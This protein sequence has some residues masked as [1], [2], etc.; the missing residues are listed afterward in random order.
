MQLLD[1]NAVLAFELSGGYAHGESLREALAVAKS[2]RN[3]GKPWT[4]RDVESLKKLARENTPTRVIGLKLG[5]TEGAVYSKASEKKVSLKPTNQSPYNRRR[6]RATRDGSPRLL[7]RP[8]TAKEIRSGT[9]VKTSDLK[10]ARQAVGRL[11]NQRGR[12]SK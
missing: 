1:K 6:K 4:Q 11:R 3:S 2:N 8:G 12:A 7:A 9:G 5:R 10:A